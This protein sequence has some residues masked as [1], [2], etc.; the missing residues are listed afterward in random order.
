MFTSDD[1]HTWLRHLQ[2]QHRSINDRL[3]RLENERIPS[4]EALVGR[5]P[6]LLLEDLQELRTELVQHFQQEE[7]GGCLEEAL[8]RCPSLCEE[9]RRI[10]GEHPQLLQDL[11]QIMDSTQKQWD[12]EEASRVKEAFQNLAHRIRAHEAA[13]S[14]ILIQGFGTHADTA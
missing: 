9:V 12:C 7:E 3:L 5:P 4:L 8:S 6:S 2:I 11:D 14:R 13:E 10:E 1:S